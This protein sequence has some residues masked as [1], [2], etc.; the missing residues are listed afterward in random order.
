[1]IEVIELTLGEDVP[2]LFLV[3]HLCDCRI[4]SRVYLFLEFGNCLEVLL[5]LLGLQSCLTRASSSLSDVAALLS[6]EQVL[7]G[8]ELLR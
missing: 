3:G 7:L 5:Q 6:E 8:F 1:M 2:G 4:H